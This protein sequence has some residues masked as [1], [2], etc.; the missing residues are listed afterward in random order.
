MLREY[1]I[2]DPEGSRHFYVT[3]STRLWLALLGPIMVWRLA[4][5]R[6]AL[7]ALLSSLTVLLLAGL[8][9]V[10]ASVLPPRLQLGVIAAAV[11]AFFG[12]QSFAGIR[13]IKRAALRRGWLV[14]RL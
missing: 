1:H 9:V 4:G 13:L 7:L 11:V 6:A 3:G 14:K 5:W 2:R 10:V 8:A 12:L